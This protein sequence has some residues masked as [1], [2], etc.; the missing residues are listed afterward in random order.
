MSTVRVSFFKIKTLMHFL[1]YIEIY[2][3]SKIK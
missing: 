2:I 3:E 1:Y